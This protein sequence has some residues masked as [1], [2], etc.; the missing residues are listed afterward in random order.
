M[1]D[2]AKKRVVSVAAIELV[3]P[4][5]DIL[6]MKLAEG[7]QMRF[8]PG[9]FVTFYVDKNGTTVTRSYSIASS[10][11]LLDRFDLLVKKVDGGYV[12]TYLTSLH[13]GEQLRMIGPL[14]RFLLRDPGNRP[15]VFVCT[16]TGIAPFIPMLEQLLRRTPSHPSCLIFGTRHDDSLLF[17]E[18]LE[19][20]SK[21]HPNFQYLPVLSQPGPGWTGSKGHVQDCLRAQFADLSQHDVYICGIP[22]MVQEVQEL[23]QELRCPKDRTFV[24]RY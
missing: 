5:V 3:A 7:D 24:E 16:G 6:H 23:V 8:D 22:Q 10:P 15:V 9:Q 13:G 12:S 21:V 2:P 14:G 11:D 1:A 17:R 4:W 20:T 19:S 18:H